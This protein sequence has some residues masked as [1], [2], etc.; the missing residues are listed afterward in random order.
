MRIAGIEIKTPIYRFIFR[1]LLYYYASY[2]HVEVSLAETI[3][4]IC[5]DTPRVIARYDE[6][7]SSP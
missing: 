5:A 1:R 7:R 4:L 2:A 6:Y 3:A